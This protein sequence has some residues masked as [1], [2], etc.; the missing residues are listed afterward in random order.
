M[1]EKRASCA[2][3]LVQIGV[4]VDVDVVMLS[5]LDYMA[6]GTGIAVARQ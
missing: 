3:W 1:G 6:V 5:L 2:M 4:D